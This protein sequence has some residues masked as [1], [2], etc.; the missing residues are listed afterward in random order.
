MSGFCC[1]GSFTRTRQCFLFGRRANS[2]GFPLLLTFGKTLVKHVKNT[3]WPPGGGSRQTSPLAPI[4]SFVLLPCQFVV[5]KSNC[6]PLN[7]TEDLLNH[8][9]GLFSKVLPLKNVF[10]ASSQMDV[11]NKSNFSQK[12]PILCVGLTHLATYFRFDGL[13][14]KYRLINPYWLPCVSKISH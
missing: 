5:K 7:V 6:S 14:L 3:F 1:S 8:L 4:G 10:W 13:S 12:A 2:K 9:P 11:W